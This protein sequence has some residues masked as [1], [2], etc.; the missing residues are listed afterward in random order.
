MSKTYGQ[1]CALARALD[2]VGDRWTLLIIRELLIGDAS[3]G[4]LASALHGVP[5][6]LL[7][8]R[9]R[10]LEDDGLLTR[11]RDDHDRR[12][13]TYQLSELGRELEPAVHALVRW[14]SHWMR[15]GPGTD[16]FQPRW[17]ALALRALLEERSG[18]PAGQ[19]AIRLADEPIVVTS[20]PRQRLY[21]EHGH[22]EHADAVVTGAPGAVLGLV[23][24]ELT[25][26]AAQ[27]LGL[28]VSGDRS[29]ARALLQP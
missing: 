20:R 12:R 28:R 13:V 14:G 4:E 9:L 15:D 19:V 24:G 10:Q 8:D 6:N 27:R 29:L 23:S 26:A 1:F 16:L 25:M 7:A 5:T 18:A 11:E 22:A 17:A 3:Y 21:V 2:H